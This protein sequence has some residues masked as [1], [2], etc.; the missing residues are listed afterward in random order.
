MEELTTG[1]NHKKTTVAMD[2]RY[3]MI[4]SEEEIRHALSHLL[5]SDD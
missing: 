2:M 3:D 4:H 1:Q 5:P